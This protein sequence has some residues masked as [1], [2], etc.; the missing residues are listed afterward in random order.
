[1]FEDFWVENADTRVVAISLA[2]MQGI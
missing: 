2:H 1:V